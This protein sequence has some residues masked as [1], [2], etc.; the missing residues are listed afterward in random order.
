LIRAFFTTRRQLSVLSL[1]P[2]ASRLSPVFAS[3]VIYCHYFFVIAFITPPLRRHI[4]Y[5][6]FAD[7]TIY[8]TRLRIRLHYYAAADITRRL[9][10]SSM[11]SCHFTI[12]YH[13]IYRCRCY[14][15]RHFHYLRYIDTID[16][17]AFAADATALTLIIAMICQ[18]IFS[19]YF[20]EA[21]A[22]PPLPPRR[23]REATA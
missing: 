15:C 18:R 17:S 20:I 5:Y 10:L 2:D 16:K 9:S 21:A 19:P 4:D 22:T 11:L 1:P 8:F 23:A 6:F 14:A 3:H 7:A 13:L 12:Q